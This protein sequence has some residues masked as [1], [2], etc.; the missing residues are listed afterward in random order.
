MNKR[1]KKTLALSLMAL[2]LGGCAVGP[3]YVRQAFRAPATWRVEYPQAAELANLRW[4]E[5]FQ[6][7]VLD[8]LIATALRENHDL[9][10]ASARVDQYLGQLRTTR[11][12]FFPQIGYGLD[13]S[14][15]RMSEK[16][17]SAPPPG[18]DLWYKQYQGSVSAAWQIDLFGRV[19]RQSEAAQ[20]QVYASE[21][22]RRGTLLTIVS[23]VA[24]SYVTLRALDRKL[25][26]ARATAAN[27]E[28]SLRVFQLRFQGGVVSQV[29]VAQVESQYQQALYAIP[30]LE[31]QVAAQ[32]NLLSVLLGRPPGPISR[33]KTIE[34]L[35]LPQVPPGLP[36]S[37]I[38][39]RPDILAAEHNLVAANANIGVARS[40]YF[41]TFS[42]TGLLGSVSTAMSSFLTAP[43]GVAMLAASVA[44]P[45]FTFGNIEGQVLTAEAAE[46]EA[47]ARYQQTILNALGETNDALLGAQKAAEAYQLQ[48]ARVK[49]LREYA[50]LS[51][52]RFENGS[53][54]YL[55]VYTA[56]ND[57]FG[58]EL[59]AVDGSADR[60]L[61]L[62]AIYKALGG[63]WVEAA[64]AAAKLPPEPGKG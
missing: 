15:N 25:E 21:E 26:I 16:S 9:R 55:E 52:L 56:E 4:W 64:E 51:R 33:G 32:E 50:R 59:V 53:A 36:A 8:T 63:G 46:R 42:L 20:A 19:R 34:A 38:E 61:Q 47:L 57:L 31:R 24:S 44:G 11:S 29:E 1:L 13:F 43:A 6:D 23:S 45:I 27:Y 10:I 3:D 39:R 18:T 48:A 37:L 41:P 49:T 35:L 22:G 54:S 12:Q 60:L 5:A 40:L 62:V 7:P 58:A 17:I 14:N 28:G 30:A 2:S